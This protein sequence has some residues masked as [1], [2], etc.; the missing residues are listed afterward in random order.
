MPT[1]NII[2]QEQSPTCKYIDLSRVIPVSAH[3][4]VDKGCFYFNVEIRK[5][6][7]NKNFEV[8]VNHL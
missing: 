4:A 1:K 5:A 7:L 3:A 2:L 8:D 6:R